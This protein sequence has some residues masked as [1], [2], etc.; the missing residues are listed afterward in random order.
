MTTEILLICGMHRSGTSL[1]AKLFELFGFSLGDHLMQANIDNPKGFFED[2]DVVALNDHLIAHNDAA[3][4]VPPQSVDRQLT[5]TDAQLNQACDLLRDKT[6]G[7]TRFAIK[8]P[9]LCLL[10]PFWEQAI[11][12]IDA[13][14]RTCIVYRNPLDISGSLESRNQLSQPTGLILT[15]YYWSALLATAPSNAIYLDYDLLLNDFDTQVERLGLWM[16]EKANANSIEAFKRDFID[17]SLRHHQH[18]LADL[19]ENKDVPSELAAIA[20]ELSAK[21]ASTDHPSSRSPGH[22]EPSLKSQKILLAEQLRRTLFV[23]RD[24][25]QHVEALELKN[26]H[27]SFE[28][29][30]LASQ[31]NERERH[32]EIQTG[33]IT[34]LQNSVRDK[35]TAVQAARTDNQALTLKLEQTITQNNAE[36]ERIS[37]QNK[38]EQEEYQR[39]LDDYDRIHRD[40]LHS[41]SFRVGRALTFPIRKPITTWILPRIQSN[42]RLLKLT[43]FARLSLSHPIKLL[44]LAS[45]RR[46][47]NLIRLI[48]QRPDLTEQ[49]VG[50][51]EDLLTQSDQRREE[52]IAPLSEDQIENPGF[53][54][55]ASRDPIL[56]I[57][58]PVYN[59]VHYTLAC[60][61]SI[62][63]HPPK[64]PFE[65]V[66]ADD[67]STDETERVLAAIP[68]LRVVRHTSNLRF[69][70]SCNRAV[71]T[72]R[73]DFIF[74]LNN[75]T[76]VQAG[77][78]D[79]LL[80]TF[81]Q[82]TDIGIAGSRLL[83]PD[84]RL[85]EAGGI[86]WN[87][88]SA[89][90]FGRL[91][92]PDAPAYSY[93]KDCDY[94]SGAAL[95]I[96]KKVFI[97]LGKFDERYAP[98]YYEDTDLCFKVRQADLR[99]VL[100]PASNVIHFE[101]VSNGTDESEGLKAFQ[102]TNRAQ[103]FDKWESELTTSHFPNAES[104]F[105]ARDRSRD[106]P[107][108]LVIDHYVPHYDKDAG[109]RSTFQYLQLLVS[110]NFQVTF[111]GD[112]FY[113]HEP[114]TRTL[115]QM[116]I[117]VLIG[118]ASRKAMT[119]WLSENAAYIDVAYLMRPH[120]A[121]D[122][123][124][125]IDA[126]TP[127]PW[128]VYFGHDLHYLRLEREAALT[129]SSDTRKDA[130]TWK[131]KEFD[132]FHRFDVVLYP[133]QVEV[134]A[135]NSI[136]PV[137]PAHTLPLNVFP[138]CSSEVTNFA[139]RS[140]LLFVGG[141]NHPPNADG[142][143]WFCQEIF[144]ELKIH[145]PG[146]QLHIVGSNMP[147]EIKSLDGDGIKVHGFL[148]DEALIE[149][150]QQVRA[151]IVPLRFGAG[152]KG[153]V[154]EAMFHGIPVF[155]TTIGAEG[156]P[157]A[158]AALFIADDAAS[159]AHNLA[160]Y[161]SDLQALQN[162]SKL[163]SKVINEHF[164]YE[165]VSQVLAQ[166]FIPPRESESL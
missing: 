125:R 109:S 22:D 81:E 59:Q 129:G 88:A 55:P 139:E 85:Q 90:N 76:L 126:M 107:H 113:P 16:G 62:A 108:I 56:S 106:K 60:L 86:V 93:L 100:Q 6:S 73:G 132:L 164:T 71:D 156:V 17:S 3:W 4:D 35:E 69:L 142:L 162:K 57:L 49:V 39:H 97:E 137:V 149:L 121:S 111:I 68:G 11:S 8:D 95:M 130:N 91:Q 87:D 9:R 135:I 38:A 163:A 10:L 15:H 140:D 161:Y 72:C 30:D 133:S 53:A 51:Y 1:T 105:L 48:F 157:C 153:K 158:D 34:S 67:C 110:N 122:W 63:E 58:V 92:D 46:A 61:R 75:D 32:I 45:P 27:Q 19:R 31:K 84:G 148:S 24:S 82:H 78:F 112:N 77:T 65:V 114:Y 102:V 40:V 144:P 80:D 101:G 120:I 143:R 124:D 20:E 119:T 104:V 43:S 89:W 134:D 66:V 13:T 136:D 2:L 41:V 96:R 123:I 154:L 26:K 36:L 152:V 74:F 29:N 118:D 127:R 141:F 18:S 115:Q 25:Q 21:A 166:H 28:I 160:T 98:S 54:F 138:S 150:Y 79:S 7:V 37:A 33:E 14:C 146:I 50:N 64:V 116:G 147:D 117:E 131:K 145:C 42:P 159:F 94:V 83:Y 165:A 47:L 155:T 128:K 23:L 12:E 44:R 151:S 70:R 103:F 52:H 99:V 5:W